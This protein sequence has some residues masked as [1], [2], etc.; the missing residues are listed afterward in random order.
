[1][2]YI[3]SYRTLVLSASSLSVVLSAQ[4][5]AQQIHPEWENPTLEEVKPTPSGKEITGPSSNSDKIQIHTKFNL[6]KRKIKAKS[7]VGSAHSTTK[8]NHWTNQNHQV[9]YFIK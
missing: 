2:K 6:L 4:Y 3:S 5:R 1:M 7:N 8:P 9:K